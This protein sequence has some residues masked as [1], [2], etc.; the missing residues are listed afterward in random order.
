MSV[1]MSLGDTMLGE[2]REQYADALKEWGVVANRYQNSFARLRLIASDTARRAADDVSDFMKNNIFTVPPFTMVIEAKDMDSWGDPAKRGPRAVQEEGDRLARQF[3]DRANR[4]V[5]VWHERSRRAARSGPHRLS[6]DSCA[7]IRGCVRAAFREST[8]TVFR[9]P[10]RGLHLAPC[11][12]S[13]T[14]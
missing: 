5:T 8:R 11:V 2:H 12:A 6:S 10:R 9:T 7:V 3:A 1:Y 4:D 13:H 14:R